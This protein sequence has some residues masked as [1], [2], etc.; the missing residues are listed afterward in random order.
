MPARAFGVNLRR[1]IGLEGKHGCYAAQRGRWAAVLCAT[2][3]L[4]V[5]R[6]SPYLERRPASAAVPVEKVSNHNDGNNE[7]DWT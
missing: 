3:A 5:A 4:R 7:T 6:N 1:Q 2:S